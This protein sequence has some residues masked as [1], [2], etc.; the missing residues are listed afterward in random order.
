MT[1]REREI[2]SR[3]EIDAI[4]READVCRLAMALDGIPY[5]IPLSFGYDGQALYIHTGRTGKK[6]DCFLGNRRVC[7]EAERSV[8]IIENPRK[9]CGWSFSFESVV[10]HGTIEEIRDPAGKEHALNRIMEHYTGK[11]WTF[12]PEVLPKTRLWRIAVD[13]VT[14]RRNRRP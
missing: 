2:E 6:I 4:L 13:T 14:G 12:D 11:T 1:R 10:G 5:V 3:E 8:R 7:F 9:A